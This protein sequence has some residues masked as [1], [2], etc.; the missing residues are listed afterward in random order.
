MQ[1]R[2]RAPFRS[3]WCVLMPKRAKEIPNCVRFILSGS[4]SG[5]QPSHDHRRR[6]VPTAGVGVNQEVAPSTNAQTERWRDHGLANHRQV[7]QRAQESEPK[8]SRSD[9][10]R[11][12]SLR[13]VPRIKAVGRVKAVGK[14]LPEAG[15]RADPAVPVKHRASRRG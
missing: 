1:F 10:Y 11:I 8:L 2:P 6:A 12:V 5:A 15:Y 13:R 14:S 3:G 4:A 9:L 7:V